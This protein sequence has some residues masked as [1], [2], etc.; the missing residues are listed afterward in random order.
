MADEGDSVMA[1]I[2]I[3]IVCVPACVG[4]VIRLLTLL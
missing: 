1:D 3:L 4:C 2:F